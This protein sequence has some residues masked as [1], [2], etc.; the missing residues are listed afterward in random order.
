MY[1]LSKDLASGPVLLKPHGSLNWY[2]TTRIKRIAAQ[3]RVEIFHDKEETERIEAFL[4][5]REIKS[6]SGHRYTPLIVPPTYLKDFT[7]PVFRRLW[8]RCTDV[9][10]T[11]K[12]LVFLGYSLPA[13]DLHSQFIFRCGFHNQI[14]GRIRDRISRYPP[15]GPAEVIIVNPDQEAARRIEEVAGPNIPCTWIS[16]RIQEWLEDG[17]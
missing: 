17:I 16:K 10:S 13:A 5:P 9:L 6:K 11:A 3:K 7:R 12:K 14:E 4:H 8:N 15:T 2:E 1:G